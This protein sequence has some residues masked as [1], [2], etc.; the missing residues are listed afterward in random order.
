MSFKRPK[1]PKPKIPKIKKPSSTSRKKLTKAI[2]S[3]SE[4]KIKP[5]LTKKNN[6]PSKPKL[7]LS[8]KKT[9]KKTGVCFSGKN[10][11]G[12][13]LSASCTKSECKRIGGKSWKGLSGCQVIS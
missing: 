8:K 10:C 6:L 1:I 13:V 11:K 3:K 12:K 7:N 2:K 9:S 4:K 5:K